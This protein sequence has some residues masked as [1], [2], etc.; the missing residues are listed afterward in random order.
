MKRKIVEKKI[1]VRQTIMWGRLKGDMVATLLNKIK[2]SGYPSIS[3][4]ANQ[5]WPIMAETIRKVVKETLGVSTG[6]PKVYKESWWWN[7]E[8]QKNK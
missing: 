6:K 1:K 8:V 7:E 3:D 5:M 2:T 4:D